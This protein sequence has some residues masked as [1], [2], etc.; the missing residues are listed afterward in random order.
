[1]F[2]D[3]VVFEL[4]GDAGALP[5]IGRKTGHAAVERFIEGTGS[6]LPQER[7]EVLDILVS[8]TRAAIIGELMSRVVATGRLIE[9]PF[10]IILAVSG[11]K[12]SRF[13]M[14]GDSFAVSAA[15]RP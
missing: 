8:D 6:L 13:L 2:A 12:I 9:S 4:P 3:D 1:M 11:G 14:L 10:A 15:A 5:W 7:F